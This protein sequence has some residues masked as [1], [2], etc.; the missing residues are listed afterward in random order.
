MIEQLRSGTLTVE[1]LETMIRHHEPLAPIAR[2]EKADPAEGKRISRTLDDVIGRYL[3][4]LNANQNR[5]EKTYAT[6]RSQ[7]ESR[8]AEFRYE[9]QRLGDVEFD[10]VTTPMIEAF[11]AAMITEGLRP[12]TVSSYMRGVEALFNWAGRQEVRLARQEKRTAVP[13]FS[14]IDPETVHTRTTTRER[15]LDEDEATRLLAATPAPLLF[16]IC[17]GLFAGFRIGEVL[18]L[19]P[20]FD[21]DLELGTLAVKDQRPIWSPKTPR[22]IRVVPIAAPLRPVLE[23]HLA[24]YASDRW[25]VPSLRDR[26]EPFV[27]GAFRLHFRAVVIAAGLNADQRDLLGVTFHTLRHTFAS[28]LVMRGVDLYTVA[29]L[30]GDRVEEVE[31]TYAR[32]SPD[33][34]RRAIDH[35]AG[36]VAMP[37]LEAT[38]GAD[39]PQHLPKLTQLVTQKEPI[40]VE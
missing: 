28:W 20:S 30:L 16:P 5:A 23:R 39:V 2:D 1:R 29:Q 6:R 35:L 21:V 40:S 38:A 3:A 17:C 10:R 32:L 8:L 13:I 15:F 9:G 22:S 7:L 36:A 34:K 26:D 33:H 11:Q 25:M 19:R 18:H 12:N 37:L 27:Y 31:A 14:P 24:R 4:R